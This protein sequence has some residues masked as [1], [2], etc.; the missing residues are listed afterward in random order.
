MMVKIIVEVLSNLGITTKEI[1][2]GRT[3][4]YFLYKYTAVDRTFFREISQEVG[5][6]G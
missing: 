2:Q 6:K 1:E 5:W 4:G 3:S